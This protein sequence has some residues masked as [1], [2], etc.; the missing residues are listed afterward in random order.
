MYTKEDLQSRE[1]RAVCHACV[2][3]GGSSEYRA[4]VV[5][6]VLGEAD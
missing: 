4:D 2:E 6:I 1:A 5:R 3:G